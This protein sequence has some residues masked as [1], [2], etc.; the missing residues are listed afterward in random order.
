MFMPFFDLVAVPSGLIFDD[1]FNDELI[2][3][4]GDIALI[5]ILERKPWAPIERSATASIISFLKSIWVETFWHKALRC[6]VKR[7]YNYC[8]K[9]RQRLGGGDVRARYV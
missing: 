6:M 7:Y 9:T 2:R 8:R 3:R 4:G 5:L 1:G